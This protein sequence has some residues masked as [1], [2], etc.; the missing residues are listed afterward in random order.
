ME[1]VKKAKNRMQQLP[2]LLMDCKAEASV[3]A[4]CVI[5]SEDVKKNDCQNEFN[6]FLECI[7][8][9]AAKRKTRII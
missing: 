1:A 7:R 6:D 3:Y 8:K 5:R 9:N 2:G 4:K